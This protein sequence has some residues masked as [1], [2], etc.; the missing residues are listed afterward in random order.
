MLKCF[1]EAYDKQGKQILGNLDGQ[2]VINCKNIKTMKFTARYKMLKERAFTP[3]AP[4]ACYRI[5]DES[6]K[7]LEEIQWEPPET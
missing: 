3:M 2:G 5:V 1:V 4:V 7:L 6:G